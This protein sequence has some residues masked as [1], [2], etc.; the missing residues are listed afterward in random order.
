[1]AG[2]SIADRLSF[3]PLQGPMVHWKG[4]THCRQGQP[5]MN[6]MK[7]LVQGAAHTKCLTPWLGLQQ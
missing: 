4:Q 3:R 5:E 7:L 6:Q 2:G 1:M